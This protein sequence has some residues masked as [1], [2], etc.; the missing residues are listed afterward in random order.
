M[1]VYKTGPGEYGSDL[2][3]SLTWL[4]LLVYSGT[5]LPPARS[6]RSM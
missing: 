5:P 3:A 2:I 1:L 4:L 6:W